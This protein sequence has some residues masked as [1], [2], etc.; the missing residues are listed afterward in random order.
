MKTKPSALVVEN[1]NVTKM[2]KNQ[3]LAKAIAEQ[4]FYEFKRQIAYKSEQYGIEVVYAD[5][6]YT[7]C[8]RCSQ[9]GNISRNFDPNDKIYRCEYCGFT[10]ERDVNASRNLA[11][12][13]EYPSLSGN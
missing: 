2:L 11:D 6:L 8:K 4:G 7:I 10:L 1:L 13:S 9:C 5:D 12:Y 3:Y